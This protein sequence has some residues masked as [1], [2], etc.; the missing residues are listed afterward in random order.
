MS[1]QLYLVSIHTRNEFKNAYNLIV[2]TE[3]V[4][5][6]TNFLKPN[7]CILTE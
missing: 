1:R 6:L 3:S 5:Y 7:L 4:N 2:Y